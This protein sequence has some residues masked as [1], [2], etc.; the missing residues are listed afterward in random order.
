MILSPLLP[1]NYKQIDGFVRCQPKNKSK[2][3]DDKIIFPFDFQFN[4]TVNDS[5]FFDY[6]DYFTLYTND[7]LND[8]DKYILN[9]SNKNYCNENISGCSYLSEKD[10][11]SFD[12]MYQDSNYFSDTNQDSN[13]SNYTDQDSN[14]FNTYIDTDTDTD[15]DIDL[16][17]NYF[18]DQYSKYF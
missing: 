16:E 4:Y 7:Y 11:I 6:S 3:K 1:K 5:V 17:F 12:D 8:D 14:Y 2:L 18:Y 13:Y 15:T 9:N 10:L